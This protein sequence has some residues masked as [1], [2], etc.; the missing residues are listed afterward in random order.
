MSFELM[1]LVR[2]IVSGAIQLV[3][4]PRRSLCQDGRECRD[5]TPPLDALP[6]FCNY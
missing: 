3:L 4:W 2:A 6:N 5:E 1:M